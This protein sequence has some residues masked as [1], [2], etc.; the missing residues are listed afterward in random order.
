MGTVLPRLSGRPP[1]QFAVR[2][3]KRFWADERSAPSSE[4]KKEISLM[5]LSPSFDIN[6]SGEN[7]QLIVPFDVK[8]H[9]RKLVQAA[10]SK[11]VSR[12]PAKASSQ[13]S[14]PSSR[15]TKSSRPSSRGGSSSALR[16]V[17]GSRSAPA[18]SEGVREASLAIAEQ[19]SVVEQVERGTAHS[20]G[21]VSGGK[22]KSPIEDKEAS[23]TRLEIV[24]I[25]DSAPEVPT[26]D[27]PA[28]ARTEPEGS[29][30]VP[31]K[32]GDKRPAPSG[33][34]APSPARK[35]SRA[36][37]GSSLALPS[38][39]KRKSVAVEP[40][41]FSSDNSL[42]ASD[43]TSESPAS[44]VADFLREQMFGGVTEA[45]D[46]RLLALTGLLA[47]ST[48]EQASFQSHSREELGSLIR[49]MLLMVTGL[50][51]EVDIR[52][53]SLRESVDRRIEEAR[54]EENISATNDARGNLVAAREQIQS[55][56]VELHS[57]LEALKKAEEKAAET[58]KHTSSLEA[59]LSR[60]RG[61]LKVSDERAA[62][63]EV[64]CKGVS[65]QLSSMAD[66]LQERNEA[67]SQKAEVQRQHDALKADL[68]GLQTR[69]NE[70]ETQREMALARVQ[71]FVAEACEAHLNEYKASGEM[72]AA[73]LKKA[74]R[75]YVTGYNRGLRE[76]R[77]APDTPLAELL[78]YEADSD[79]C[80]R[81]IC[82][83][84]E[85][86]SE[87]SELEGEDV[88]VLGSKDDDPVSEGENPNLGSEVAPA[89]NIESSDPRDTELPADMTANR[90]NVGE[91]VLTNINKFLRL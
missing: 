79:D 14:K 77:H 78:K 76:A 80:R 8:Y 7:D 36:A 67:L 54:L 88:E 63:L 1:P 42:K 30:G 28:P 9:F 18:S 49:E 64:R 10:S 75:M 16:P 20:S 43:I 27:A 39:G 47:S 89:V 85:I 21:E 68:E 22:S 11:E 41:L 45:S 24:L 46:P 56:Q 81:N 61:V 5:P 72:G 57:A 23:G 38:I 83:P 60:T 91:E 86:S 40:P 25:E 17:E 15:S 51:M 66:A 58:A 71:E 12:P 19:T 3:P 84:T 62:A 50:L 6:G 69:L 55:L 70:V 4:K 44:A 35:K 26:Q 59:E 32:T 48:K 31:S 53:R 33:T 37:A 73:I 13:A 52:D 74:F 34:A 82:Q 29:E 2:A 87:E 65:E 90:D